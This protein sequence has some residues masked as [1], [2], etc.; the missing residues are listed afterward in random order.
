M[1]GK[2]L[3]FL[4]TEDWFV[5]SHFLP[6]VR[7]ARAEGYDVVVAARLS[8]ALAKEDV[9]L[10]AMPFN[11]GGLD[12]ITLAFETAAVRRLVA[13]ER[14][15]IVHAIALKPIAMSLW[16]GAAGAARVFAL[17]GRG[18]LATSRMRPLADF[19]ARALRRAL[20]AG[21]SALLVENLADRAWV[22]RA[23]PLPEA[24]VTLMPGAGVDAERFTPAPFP[25]PPIAIGIAA[26]LVRSKGVD[27]A[28]EAVRRLNAEGAGLRLRLAGDVDADNPRGV[29][30]RTLAAW[31]AV[32]GVALLGRVRDIPAFWADAH[33]AC[34]PSRGG[35][36]LPRTL[37][38]AAACGR[39]IVTTDTPGCADFVRDGRDGLVVAPNDPAALAAALLK[40]A[41]DADLREAM[42]ASAR[43]RVLAGHTE[44]HAAD[45]AAATW[46][47]L[48]AAKG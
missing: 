10:V 45:A 36:G 26:R 21:R 4:A 41:R 47:R 39:P 25:P 30:A 29:G 20:D 35:E 27:V 3:I 34:L 32:E 7:R 44:R 31:R 37:L 9:R 28:V 23:G 11:R 43:L 22:E 15:D 38:E 1:S 17:T 24:C 16:A 14:P 40:L 8:G 2:K 19:I 18:Y 42:G 12:P 5:A 33:I 46:A 48:L 13:A 6:L